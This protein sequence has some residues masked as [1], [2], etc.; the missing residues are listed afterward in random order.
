[1]YSAVLDVLFPGSRQE[2]AVRALHAATREG[3]VAVAEKIIGWGIGVDSVIAPEAGDA[4]KA[5]EKENQNRPGTVCI[6]AVCII[7]GISAAL[8]AMRQ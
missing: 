8:Q 6:R 7:K 3:Q 1:M 4:S 5:K 2:I